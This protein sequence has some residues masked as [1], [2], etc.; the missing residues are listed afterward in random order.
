[1][2]TKKQAKYCGKT[3]RKIHE[4]FFNTADWGKNSENY[5]ISEEYLMQTVKFFNDL[6]EENEDDGQIH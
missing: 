5:N 3:I 2:E 4:Y 1:M 6:L